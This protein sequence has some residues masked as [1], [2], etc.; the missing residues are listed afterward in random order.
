MH[1]TYGQFNNNDSSNFNQIN[2]LVL[3]N[4][5]LNRD[6]SLNIHIG[7]GEFPH[8]NSTGGDFMG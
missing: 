4:D 6:S 8:S 7:H 2:S 5:N 3:P 1:N